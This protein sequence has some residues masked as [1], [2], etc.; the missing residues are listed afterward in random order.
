MSRPLFVSV[1]RKGDKM[2]IEDFSPDIPPN[3]SAQVSSE[4]I[5]NNSNDNG[6]VC[7]VCGKSAQNFCPRC[8]QDFCDVHHCVMHDTELPNNVVDEPLID[9]EGVEHRGRRI[10]LIGEGWPNKLRMIKDMS[11][12]ELEGQ[13]KGLQSLLQDAIKTADYARI[14]IAAREYELDYRKHS[15]YVAAMKR[16]E[17]IEQGAVR[18]GGRTHRM[19]ASGAK[20]AI[21]ADIAALMKLANLTYEQALL[22]KGALG[23]VKK[24]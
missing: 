23:Q 8:G 10:R 21:P 13:I 2:P 12:P 24:S 5:V 19:D 22:L 4:S 7:A 20:I 9:D 18:L 16:R 3:D 6:S 1:R 17:K 14:S 15:R 11:D